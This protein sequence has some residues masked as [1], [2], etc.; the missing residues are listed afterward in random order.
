MYELEA[1][2]I[3]ARLITLVV[4]LLLLA[5]ALLLTVAEYRRAR[6]L[7]FRPLLAALT[8]QVLVVGT[9]GFLVTSDR[10]RHVLLV[11]HFLL[12]LGLLQ[13]ITIISL[14]TYYVRLLDSD[15]PE[16]GER[17]VRTGLYGA[18]GTSTV[19]ALVFQTG[20]L[21]GT[22]TAAILGQA[23]LS[24]YSLGLTV[25]GLLLLWPQPDP[26]RR[27]MAGSLI[28]YGMLALIAFLQGI[29]PHLYAPLF[30][31]YLAAEAIAVL[32]L[33]G[34][35]FVQVTADLTS[36]AQDLAMRSAGLEQASAALRHLQTASGALLRAGSVKA[37]LTTLLDTLALQLGYRNAMVFLLDPRRGEWSSHRL[38]A[39]TGQAMRGESLAMG[40]RLFFTELVLAGRPVV[41]SGAT[42]LLDQ[43]FLVLT[44]FSKHV[45]VVPL[46][47][48]RVSYNP[49]GEPTK[50]LMQR[51]S[52]WK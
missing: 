46:I 14:L 6:R 50:T 30:P 10:L 45:A 28:A 49:H 41:F 8:T 31:L 16:A 4:E 43:D 33:V 48:P 7:Q 20:W 9:S 44:G 17:L 13:A 37:L 27:W 36:I 29:L 39:I 15:D 22:P 25:A 5:L 23:T 21:Y 3:T 51:G 26:F 38:S 40:R 2:P 11:P 35:S 24:L 47:A 32:G 34:V 52:A 19:L 18:L 42:Q 12:A 1:A